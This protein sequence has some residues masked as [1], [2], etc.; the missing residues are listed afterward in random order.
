MSRHFRL[1]HNAVEKE[2]SDGYGETEIKVDPW[3]AYKESRWRNR[4]YVH[5][6][7]SL[8]NVRWIHLLELVN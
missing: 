3:K 1:F 5:S 4:E 8:A 7:G 6:L 2:E